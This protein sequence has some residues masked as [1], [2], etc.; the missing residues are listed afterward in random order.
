MIINKRSK[1]ATKN[2]DDKID[3]ILLK[4]TSIAEILQ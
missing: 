1:T 4:L 2:F 3:Q